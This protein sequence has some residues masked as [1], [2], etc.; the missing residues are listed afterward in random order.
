[1]KNL[2]IGTVIA[3]AATQAG[4]CIIEAGDDTGGDLA[5]VGA[6]WALRNVNGSAAAS[7]PPGYNTAA[8]F[9]VAVDSSGTPLAPCTG[10]GSRSDTCFVD[11]FDCADFAGVSDFLP[12]RMYQTWISITDDTGANTYAQSLSAFLDV[13]DIDLDFNASIFTDGGFFA[14][15]WE[16]EGASSGSPLECA[17]AGATGVE[18]IVTVS[19]GSTMVDAG[20]PWNCEDHYGVTAALPV[21]SYTVSIDAFNNDGAL[22]VVAPLTNK[23]IQAPNRVTDLGSIII[24]IDGL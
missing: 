3:L 6:T 11:L 5:T 24:P 7:C 9:N 21:G 22:G 4:G 16:L 17:A 19:G 13:R 20:D 14:L 15:D 8:L 23:S 18:T 2:V 10:P 12:P 1:M